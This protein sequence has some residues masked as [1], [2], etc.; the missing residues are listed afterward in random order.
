M[1]PLT[2][3][4]A[5]RDRPDRLRRCLASL[6]D[7]LGDADEVVVVDSASRGREAVADVVA[8]A[9]RAV[10]VVRAPRPGTSL[11]R[12]LGGRA[13]RH[14]WVAFVDDD[15]TVLSGWADALRA[16]IERASPDFVTGRIDVPDDQRGAPEPNP[17]MTAPEP[18]RIDRWR[19]GLL[20][21]GANLAV[22]VDAL[23]AV[24]GFDERL[25]PGTRLRAGEDHELMDRLLQRGYVGAYTPAARVDHDQWRSRRESLV[26]HWRIGLGGGARLTRLAR[27]DRERLPRVA[28]ELLVDDIAAAVAGSLRAGYRTGTVFALLRLAGLVAG[29]VATAARG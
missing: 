16:T 13:A 17:S 2:V 23:G 27:H 11:A 25:G 20:G 9:P 10:R 7:D 12:N 19:R 26:V 14:P 22:R 18:F 4:V 5:T 3:V 28:R 8:G 6:A 29:I 24:G 1:T 21:A 15:V